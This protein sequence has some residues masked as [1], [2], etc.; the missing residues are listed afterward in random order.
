MANKI[1]TLIR[2]GPQEGRQVWTNLLT[3]TV[4][5]AEKR[6]KELYQEIFRAPRLI[7]EMARLGMA[8]KEGSRCSRKE[9]CGSPLLSLARQQRHQDEDEDESMLSETERPPKQDWLWDEL[10]QTGEFLEEVHLT[11]RGIVEQ[12]DLFEVKKE[13]RMDR[14][15]LEVMADAH[16]A[17]GPIRGHDAYEESYG[18]LARLNYALSEVSEALIYYGA[19]VRRAQRSVELW[20]A[21]LFQ[22]T[23]LDLPL[24]ASWSHYWS[25]VMN[26]SAQAFHSLESHFD[27]L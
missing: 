13:E 3:N 6:R 5:L 24:L 22:P 21:L 15:M 11:L 27:I 19:L 10:E 8:T 23:P 7:P 17:A 14:V 26:A 4:G 1:T 25:R 16:V 9:I 18:K 20:K 12:V 2:L